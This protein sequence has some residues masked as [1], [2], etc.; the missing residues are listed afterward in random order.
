MIQRQTTILARQS[1]NRSPRRK[2]IFPRAPNAVSYLKSSL[3]I[4]CLAMIP[5]PTTSLL[6]PSERWQNT[7]SDKRSPGAITEQYVDSLPVLILR[8]DAAPVRAKTDREFWT[9]LNEFFRPLLSSH[10][11]APNRFI[12][13]VEL[14]CKHR[15]R[16]NN[17]TT[18]F[19]PSR[20][21]RIVGMMMS[22]TPGSWALSRAALLR[23]SQ[24]STEMATF[25]ANS[26]A[27]A[28]G[29]YRFDRGKRCD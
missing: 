27:Q 8:R 25:C 24:Y 12:V 17:F 26:Y 18:T 6:P 10:K 16:R 7:A 4:R 23:N 3:R 15:P 29:F 19:T 5:S 2:T 1:P 9:V 20:V 14:P 28:R 21:I 11:D 22:N 13:K